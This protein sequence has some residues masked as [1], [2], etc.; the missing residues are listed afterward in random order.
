MNQWSPSLTETQQ[1]L[2]FHLNCIKRFLKIPR[3]QN[4]HI[5]RL[6]YYKGFIPP[7]LEKRINNSQKS[8]PLNRLLPFTVKTWIWHHQKR[9][10]IYHLVADC[11]SPTYQTIALV[12]VLLALP[13]HFYETWARTYHHHHLLLQRQQEPPLVLERQILAQEHQLKAYQ[14][15]SPLR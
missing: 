8:K 3:K 6:S 15:V 5:H 2:G 9:A 1:K 10:S 14:W 4:S 13:P 11:H 7:I 12:A